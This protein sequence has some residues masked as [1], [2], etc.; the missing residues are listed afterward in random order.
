VAADDPDA[1]RPLAI[2][3]CVDGPRSWRADQNAVRSSSGLVV[4]AALSSA[5][6]HACKMLQKYGTRPLSRSFHDADKDSQHL[7]VRVKAHQGG[8]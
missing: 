7:V 6:N 8:R 1:T 2:T 3:L 4:S 5:A